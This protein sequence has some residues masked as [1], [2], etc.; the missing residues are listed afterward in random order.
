MITLVLLPGMDGTGRLF[1]PF[2]D[3]LGAGID[4]LRIRYPTNAPMGYV[5][6]E[7]RVRASIPAER[8]FIVLAESFS[9]P[10]A[11]SMAASGTPEMKGLILC[12]SFARNPRPFFGRMRSL[13]SMASGARPPLALLDVLLLGSFSTAPLRNALALAIA[14]VEP[15]VL[16]RRLD[17]VLS[18]D[19][20]STLGSIRVPV[21]Y[22]RALRDRMV[23]PTAAEH[24]ASACSGVRIVDI[25]APH[26]LLQAVPDEAA[27]IVRDFI[28]EIDG[29]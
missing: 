13:I 17:A 25:D 5:E 24:V 1:D 11:L 28:L 29:N 27:C 12:C 26:F 16:G 2:L 21:L 7:K 19:V 4:V 9:G 15:A 3:S 10:I 14:E 20:S 23:P 18:I 6:L 8:A 22:L